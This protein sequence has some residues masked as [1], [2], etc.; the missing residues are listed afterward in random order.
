[1]RQSVYD[2]VFLTENIALASF[3][4]NLTIEPMEYQRAKDWTIWL[5]GGLHIL[6]L[7]L[8]VI[9]YKKLHVWSDLISVVYRDSEE[10]LVF[11]T[12][13]L[14]LQKTRKIDTVIR[15]A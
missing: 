14:F 10:D 7:L 3:G 12:E 5:S 6:G 15:R 9:Y 2:L 8:K 1:M 13:F 11:K 4:Y